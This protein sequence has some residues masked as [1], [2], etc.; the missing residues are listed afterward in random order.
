MGDTGRHARLNRNRVGRGGIPPPGSNVA[1]ARDCKIVIQP[2]AM[3]VNTV[4]G[5][6]AG[7]GSVA[8]ADDGSR[9]R[10]GS[11]KVAMPVANTALA[12]K[13][14]VE[15]IDPGFLPARTHRA[16]HA[17]IDSFVQEAM[18]GLLIGNCLSRTPSSL[19]LRG[20]GGIGSYSH[21]TI[22]QTPFASSTA[23]SGIF[24]GRVAGLS[25]GIPLGFEPG[26]Q[27]PRGMGMRGGAVCHIRSISAGVRP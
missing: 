1:A 26:S 5:G 16:T 3:L 10:T 14:P 11:Q 27:A 17:R 25:D 7:D 13:Q 18:T 24:L 8:P 9:K 23:G 15:R 20:C 6:R 19:T 22:Y 2:A 12:S 21:K 4:P